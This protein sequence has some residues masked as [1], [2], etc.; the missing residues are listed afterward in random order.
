MSF[1]L[2]ISAFQQF[3]F[4][5]IIIDTTFSSKTFVAL[6]EHIFFWTTQTRIRKSN[7]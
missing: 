4:K 5:L 2:T 6:N 3:F 1:S 7:N